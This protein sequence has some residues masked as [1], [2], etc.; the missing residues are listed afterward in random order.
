MQETKKEQESVQV[1]EEKTHEERNDVAHIIQPGTPEQPADL[2][3]CPKCRRRVSKDSKQCPSCRTLL[4]FE[5]IASD[6]RL[7]KISGYSLGQLLF[8]EREYLFE[9]IYREQDLDHKLMYY[10]AF[11]CFFA[12][13]FGFFLGTF[14]GGWQP[15]A[16]AIK[17]PILLFGTLLICTPALFTFNV[18]MGS[19]LSFKQTI[20]MLVVS[21]YLIS[22]VLVSLAPIMFF[23]ILS[24][25]SRQFI[26]LL[27]VIAFT[28]S[29]GFGISLLW[30][31]MR[32]LTIKSGSE[33]DGMTLPIWSVIYMFV[34]TQ[35]AWIMRPF[36]GGRSSFAIFRTVEDNFYV[37]LFKMISKMLSVE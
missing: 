13:I 3:V 33:P 12:A 22:A 1:I 24:G 27:N 29:G 36:I 16:A 37:A 7:K 35:L 28:I 4:F 20:T 26:T 10:S 14:S 30:A 34:G 6:D 17:V 21:T 32:Y 23:F 9:E 15:L 31:G 18:L 25:S 8:R 19:K 11:A 5:E 2:A